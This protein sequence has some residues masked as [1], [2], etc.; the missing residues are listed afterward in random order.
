V[1]PAIT[2]DQIQGLAA[3]LGLGENHV[4]R[5]ILQARLL[6]AIFSQKVGRDVLLKGGLAMHAAFHSKRLTKDVDLQV[7]P[8][9]PVARTRTIIRRAIEEALESG[10]LS[11]P[12]ITEPKQTDTVQRWKINGM[13][14]ETLV[15]MTVEV[16]RR[17]LPPA[18][19][20]HSVIYE[21]D[22]DYGVAPVLI[23]SYSPTAIAAGKVQA[24]ASHNRVAPRDIFD[25][26]MLIKMEI[27][28]PVKLLA[29]MG[30]DALRQILDDLWD[31][32]EAMPYA[33]A[34]DALIEYLPREVAETF[35]EQVWDE[36][37]LRTHRAVEVWLKEAL[38]QADALAPR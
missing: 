38:E 31:K 24:L 6:G 1:K 26:D 30:P 37:R 4:V 32:I 33:M 18:E 9:M 36:M 16:S 23:E 22:P 17:G 35:D 3:R 28:P 29:D 27:R 13:V 25:L 15:N 21:P 5:D 8:Q 7:N 19:Y 11:K 20:A 2:T 10:L 34:R 12:V 14:G